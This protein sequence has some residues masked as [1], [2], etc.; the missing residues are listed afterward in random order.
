MDRG[1]S[2]FLAK[3]IKHSGNG[4]AF[5]SG[6]PKSSWDLDLGAW[7]MAITMKLDT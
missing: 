5:I 4:S 7:M 6:V 2:S 3:V 1:Q